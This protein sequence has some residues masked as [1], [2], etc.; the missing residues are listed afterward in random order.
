MTTREPE[1]RKAGQDTK[2]RIQDSGFRIQD[3]GFRIQD[4]RCRCI[5][6]LAS[7]ILHHVS[8]F[9]FHPS[10]RSRAS[11]SRFTFYAVFLISYYFVTNSWAQGFG[12]NK[13]T[14]QHFDWLIHRTEH[15]DIH[16]YPSE[17]RLV[18]ILADIAE[19]AYEKHSEDFKHEIKDRTPIILYQSHKDF[20]ETNIILDEIQEGVGGFSEIFKRRVV[21]P[22][23]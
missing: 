6:H 2:F 22:F 13:V 15:F 9:T 3:S 8:R 11:L 21:I 14:D 10:L 18:P 5:L 23:T 16:Y 20:Q 12:K 7:C 19:E 4:S 17:S 1:S